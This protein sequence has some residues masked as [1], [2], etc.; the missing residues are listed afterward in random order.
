M[1]RFFLTNKKSEFEK[2]EIERLLPILEKIEL[3]LIEM[4]NAI[5]IYILFKYKL[6]YI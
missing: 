1:W 3:K 6:I 2:F 5:P 4:E